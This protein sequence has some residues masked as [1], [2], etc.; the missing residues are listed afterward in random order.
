MSATLCEN[1]D[2]SF[3]VSA[4]LFLRPRLPENMDEADAD[5]A[6]LRLENVRSLQARYPSE[7]AGKS[8]AKV[9]EE[10]GLDPLP[11]YTLETYRRNVKYFQDQ[12]R[13]LIEKITQ[14]C[15]AIHCYE[16]QAGE[17]EGWTTSDAAEICRSLRVCWLLKLPGYDAAAYGSPFRDEDEAGP[18]A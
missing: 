9:T 15:K 12:R 6:S 16:Y 10:W 18:A 4:R 8:V 14:V 13:P 5:Q 2:L 7:F 1:A 17:H 3:L 11:E